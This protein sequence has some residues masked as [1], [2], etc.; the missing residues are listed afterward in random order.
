M[1][2]NRAKDAARQLKADIKNSMRI[3]S[4]STERR[5]LD[6]PSTSITSGRNYFYAK[7][8]ILLNYAYKACVFSIIWLLKKLNI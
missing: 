6:T 5:T 8:N 4:R 1:A 3:S 7:K 2:T